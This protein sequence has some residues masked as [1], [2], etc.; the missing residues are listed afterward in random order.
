MFKLPNIK[1]ILSEED[2]DLEPYRSST[3]NRIK[4]WIIMIECNKNKPSRRLSYFDQI[5][6][7][8]ESFSKWY[9]SICDH[10]SN[11]ARGFNYHLESKNH[12]LKCG[13]ITSMFCPYCNEEIEEGTLQ[14]HLEQ[15]AFC[16][17][18]RKREIRKE[19]FKKQRERDIA[20]YKMNVND[21]DIW[22][23]ELKDE[24]NRRLRADDGWYRDDK[25]CLVKNELG[26]LVPLTKIDG[27]EEKILGLFPEKKKRQKRKRTRT[28]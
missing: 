25:V 4:K 28:C 21:P 16:R 26:L 8:H 9:C 14:D 17:D 22:F 7:R 6:T 15:K 1:R 18:L 24:Y 5:K 20:L 11:S 12:K 2:I 19:Y 3:D 27:Y 23:D 13:K 10:Q